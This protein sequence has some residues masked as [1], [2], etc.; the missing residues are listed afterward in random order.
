MY[1]LSKIAND[2]WQVNPQD[3]PPN[4]T[5]KVMALCKLYFTKG[6]F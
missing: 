2:D 5:P 4:S 1:V 6:E 3:N